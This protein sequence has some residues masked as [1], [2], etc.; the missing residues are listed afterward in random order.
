MSNYMQKGSSSNSQN[1]ASVSGL[2][3]SVS[4]TPVRFRNN[5]Q[6]PPGA[7]R[8]ASSNGTGWNRA[9]ERPPPIALPPPL[10]RTSSVINTWKEPELSHT[11]TEKDCL[12]LR[13]MPA[14][15]VPNG[16]L[17]GLLRTDSTTRLKM[18]P[19]TEEGASVLKALSQSDD[20]ASLMMS[21]DGNG[22]VD[23]EELEKNLVDVKIQ[24]M[25]WRNLKWSRDDNVSLLNVSTPDQQ[26]R[27]RNTLGTDVFLGLDV[28]AICESPLFTVEGCIPLDGGSGYAYRLKWH[29]KPSVVLIVDAK[30]AEGRFHNTALEEIRDEMKGGYPVEWTNR[31]SQESSQEEKEA[32]EVTGLNRSFTPPVNNNLLLPMPEVSQVYKRKA[33]DGPQYAWVEHN[34]SRTLRNEFMK[35]GH[36]VEVVSVFPDDTWPALNFRSLDGGIVSIDMHK[37]GSVGPYFVQAEEFEK[38]MELVSEEEL[39]KEKPSVEQTSGGS[40]SEKQSRSKLASLDALQRAQAN[41][42]D[43]NDLPINDKKRKAVENPEEDMEEE[44]KEASTPPPKKRRGRPKGS[45][46]KKKSDVPFASVVSNQTEYFKM[47]DE[48]Q[49]QEAILTSIQRANGVKRGAVT[50]KRRLTT[51][52]GTSTKYGVEGVL[53]KAGI[54]SPISSPTKVQQTLVRSWSEISDLAGVDQPRCD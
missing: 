28:K 18:S 17:Q 49:H 41:C 52:D 53:N 2:R 5:V 21:I 42:P 12:T 14:V 23:K 40:M 47:R 51:M 35:Q 4:L 50:R 16:A 9:V 31:S 25:T 33:R 7:P 24:N 1:I 38:H 34:G 48:R 8:K 43:S 15:G 36:R 32:E 29:R 26:V 45:K 46:K 10:E 20:E 27:L 3:R 19:R 39:T 44:V 54:I 13:R 22:N 11:V 6:S 37:S 30:V